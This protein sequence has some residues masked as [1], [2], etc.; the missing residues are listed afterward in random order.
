[1][2]SQSLRALERPDWLFLAYTLSAIVALTLGTGLVY[3]WGIAGAAAGL[4][5]CQ[6]VTAVLALVSYRRL[7]RSSAREEGVET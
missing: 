5:I 6:V 3:L 4:V 1:V 2:L 7:Q